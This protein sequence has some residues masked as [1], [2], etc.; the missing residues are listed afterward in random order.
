MDRVVGAGVPVVIVFPYWSSTVTPTDTVAPA[1]TGEAGW[2][3]IDQL[4]LSRR[5]SP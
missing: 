2:V 5:G 3:V 1:A 4:V